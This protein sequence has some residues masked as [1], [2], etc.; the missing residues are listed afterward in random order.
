M[1][2]QALTRA[3]AV[4][5]AS[6]GARFSVP[7]LPEEARAMVETWAHLLSDIPDELGFAAFAQHCRASNRPPTPADVR[8]LCELPSALPSAG[9][10]WAEVIEAAQ[11]IGYQN[12]V[13]PAMSCPEVRAAAR[14]AGWSGICFA[15]T[16]MQLSTT[17]AHFFRIYDGLA[18]R[19]DREQQRAAIEGS[20]PAGLLPRFKSVD[21]A[22]AKQPRRE[23]PA[24][25]KESA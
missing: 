20:V 21:E 2:A 15:E 19:T 5:S 17:R 24:A 23:L 25:E 13:V 18:S 16:E 8:K 10:A 6:Y 3:F 22:I 14:A 1:T 11:T 9:E 12:G 7:S 4:C